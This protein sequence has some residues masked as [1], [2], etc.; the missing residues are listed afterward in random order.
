MSENVPVGGML[1][2]HKELDYVYVKLQ[3]EMHIFVRKNRKFGKM[4]FNR[5]TTV[6]KRK[7]FTA[8]LCS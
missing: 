5:K 4:N 3:S 7:I 2:K 6:F 8:C 1:V